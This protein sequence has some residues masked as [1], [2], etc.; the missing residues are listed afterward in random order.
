MTPAIAVATAGICVTLFWV[1]AAR[2]AAGRDMN[3]GRFPLFSSLATMACAGIAAISGSTPG[4]AAAL[5]AGVAIAGTIDART[6]FIFDPLTFALIACGLTTSAIDGSLVNGVLGA[7]AVGGALIALFV[8]TRGNGI[9]LG[10]VKLGVG[11]GVAL[12]AARGLSAIGLAF[13]FGAVYAIWLL[14][15]HRADRRSAVRFGPFMAVG[16]FAAVLTPQSWLP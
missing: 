9:G 10:D 5:L 6:G 1:L 8:L 3:V 13:I 16:T 7:S 2:T 14:A 12:G 11:I 15:R 4:E